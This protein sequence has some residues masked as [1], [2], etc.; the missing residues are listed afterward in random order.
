MCV[1]MRP[2]NISPGSTLIGSCITLTTNRFFVTD[3][4]SGHVFVFDATLE[5]EVGA[6]SVPGAYGIDD[7]PDHS[8]LYVGTYIGD[9]YTI[10][11][12]SMTVSRRYVASQIGPY[13][14]LAFN[15]VV[16]AD[17][18]VALL[19]AEGGIANVDGSSSIALWNPADNSIKIWGTM[20]QYY[21]ALLPCGAFM[22]NIGGFARTGDRSKI[23][24]GSVDSDNTLCEIEPNS[25]IG[26]YVTARGG[27]YHLLTTPDGKY[28]ILPVNSGA[29]VYDAQT[30]TLV[31]QFPVGGDGTSA[32]GFAVSA[33]SKTL[34]TPTDSVVYAY[35]LNTH[36]QVGW[37]PNIPLPAVGGGFNVGPG[38]SANLQ[39]VDGTG[40]LAGPMEE[41]IGFV[42]SA[43]MQKGPVGTIFGN[44]F[45][46]PDNGPASG[47]TPTQW[48]SLMKSG[49][50]GSVYFGGQAAM[51]ASVA[52]GFIDATTPPGL[53]GPVDIYAFSTDGGMEIVPEGFSYG[54][55]NLET[56]PNMS[57]VEGGGMGA[58][59]GYGLMPQSATTIPSD[60][61]VS[62]GGSPAT[63][64]GVTPDAY[65]VNPHPFPLEG[66]L[67]TIPPAVVGRADVTVSNKS[68]TSTA[69]G[70]LR[71]LPATRQYSLTDASLAQGIYDGHRDVYYFTDTTQVRVFSLTQQQWL[72]PIS[73][74][75]P[76]G[77]TQRLW[78]IALSP[79]GTKLAIADISAGVIYELNPSSPGVV[80]T[81]AVSSTPFGTVQPVGLA[82]SDS[83]MVYY[84][85]WAPDVSGAHGFF[86]LNTNTGAITDFGITSPGL[87]SNGQ[88][89]DV[90]LRSVIS[91]DNARV[92]FNQDGSIFSVDTASNTLFFAST[93]VSCCYGDYELTLSSNQ[94]QLEGS[95]YLYDADLNASSFLTM[96]DRE[97]FNLQYVYGAKLSPDGRLLFQPSVA[98]IDVFDGKLGNLLDRIAMPFSLSTKY[99]ALVANGKDNVLIAITGQSGTGIAVVDLTSIQEP[100][101]LPYYRNA[102]SRSKH[103]DWP[104]KV[105]AQRRRGGPTNAK[106]ESNLRLVPRVTQPPL[107]RNPAQ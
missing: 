105:V 81:F 18:K 47:G 12:V 34:Y 36:K 53:P 30:L 57:T 90:Y 64:I 2:P 49:N 31:A 59:F 5:T 43:A 41:G 66:I 8:T 23:L 39:A 4:F 86:K 28:I 103:L 27:L 82:V 83:G 61:Q 14:Y 107:A 17:G 94:T 96:N 101:P 54:P 50:L 51:T 24:I 15:A 60:L 40:L 69:T 3:P 80:K 26:N 102:S 67:F 76:G 68:G 100:P 95:S 78:G 58:L 10:D 32:S 20:G 74:P 71:Y 104:A 77:A 79:D 6:I 93:D 29:V 45:L 35:D 63:I 91:S 48:S 52:N 38:Y 9:I 106:A 42:D 37:F 7:T 33:D 22:G 65:Q 44:A 13:G 73:I 88:P 87:Y 85:T 84:A 72:T 70:A 89:L 56:T 97:I 99:D 98:G 62:V 16:M 75:A 55:T 21:G 25:G 19:G 1:P 92:Y 11:P 46:N